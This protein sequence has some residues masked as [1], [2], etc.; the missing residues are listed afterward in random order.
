[1]SL[2]ETSEQ[3]HLDA[4]KPLA[5]KMRPNCLDEFQGQQHFLGPGKLLRKLVAADR[6]GSVLFFG[7]P[8]TGKTTLARILA[9]ATKRRFAQLS[10]ILHGVKD[11]REVLQK[12]RDDVA[13]GQGGTLLFI[14]EMI[15]SGMDTSGVEAALAL[16]KKMARERSKS[17]WL[18]SHKD[19]L[20][21]RVNNLLKVVK[22]NGF[23][24]YST[25]I[26]I[27]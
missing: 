27:A 1:M 6:L 25:D 22:E 14:D 21:G 10:A 5:A 3:S 11:L 18:V 16:L 19:E 2:F 23:T 26:D 17:I 12:A 8:G 24:S 9:T 13:T 7:P 15:D 20:A 4:A